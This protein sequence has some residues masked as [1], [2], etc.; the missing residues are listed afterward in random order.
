MGN[1]QGFNGENIEWHQEKIREYF[2]KCFD[3][4]YN[5]FS[6]MSDDLTKALYDFV[7]D[8]SHT[9]P[10]AESAKKFID[11]RQIKLVEEIIHTIQLL[12]EMMQEDGYESES[13]LLEDFK[14]D[15]SEDETAVI[16]KQH[17]EKVAED[18]AGYNNAFLELHP[19]ISTIHRNVESIA[20]S[21]DAISRKE[22]TKPQ[23]RNPHLTMN[24]FT[25]T[26]KSEGC[27]PKF[28]KDFLAFHE[29]HCLKSATFYIIRQE[30]DKRNHNRYGEGNI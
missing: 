1:A 28:L 24:A 5:P 27:V 14:K 6:R 3:E 2:N 10:E 29:E 19:K 21:C 11:E 16:K 22:Y 30:Q 17:L 18:F 23:P 4:I 8:N 12:K 7:N 26:D 20:N 15:L 25:N 9:G 13:A